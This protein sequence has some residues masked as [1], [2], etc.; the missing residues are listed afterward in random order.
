MRRARLS[1]REIL[2]GESITDIVGETDKA[3]CQREN[4]KATFGTPEAY[5]AQ[6]MAKPIPP[7]FTRGAEPTPLRTPQPN[8]RGPAGGVRSVPFP[9]EGTRVTP[10]GWARSV[11]VHFFFWLF[12]ER[13]WAD[14]HS[15]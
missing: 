5:Y 11:R 8:L 9:F 6:P 4:R 15:P 12:A 14:T 3:T 2:H 1:A 7:W 10:P 13:S